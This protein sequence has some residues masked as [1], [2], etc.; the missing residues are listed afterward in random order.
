M[1][2]RGFSLWDQCRGG[3]GGWDP[4]VDSLHESAP[5]SMCAGRALGQVS[6]RGGGRAGPVHSRRS[7]L[8]K[9]PLW[10]SRPPCALW[11]AREDAGALWGPCTRPGSTKVPLVATICPYLGTRRG[12]FVRLGHG[13]GGA[14]RLLPNARAQLGHLFVPFSI[15]F[16]ESHLSIKDPSPAL[17]I[18]AFICPYGDPRF[19][20]L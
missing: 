5:I 11:E 7:L 2:A 18:G 13:K 9:V 20:C 16:E 17:Q 6:H 15:T 4:S 8:T 12:T 10:G 1:G 19:S 14:G 3:P